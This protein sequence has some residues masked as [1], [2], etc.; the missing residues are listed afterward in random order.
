MTW[1][2]RYSTA[3]ADYVGRCRPCHSRLDEAWHLLTLLRNGELVL[4]RAQLLEL[5]EVIHTLL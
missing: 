3:L 4:D 5:D 2:R 1:G